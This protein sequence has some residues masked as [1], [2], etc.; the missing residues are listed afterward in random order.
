MRG[1]LIL[2]VF[3][4]ALLAGL[5]FS[6]ARRGEPAPA[7][8]GSVAAPSS[9]GTSLAPQT[10]DA[11]GVEVL[12]QPVRLDAYGAVFRVFLDTHSGDLGVD[13]SAAARLEV[14]GRSWG[15]PTW[16]GDP[17]GG[18]HR[19]GRLT[20]P[21]AGAAIG[22]ARLTIEGLPAPVAASWRIGR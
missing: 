8:G 14:G 15:I 4:V 3:V 21:A 20:F 9:G 13:L 22:T 5:A 12:I 19:E 17:P 18:H 7:A 6:L 1:R 16:E 11:G 2:I 10:L